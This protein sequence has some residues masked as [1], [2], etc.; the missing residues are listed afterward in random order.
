MYD[1]AKYHLSHRY[2]IR[3]DEGKQEPFNL[4][5]LRISLYALFGKDGASLIM[6]AIEEELDKLKSK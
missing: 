6:T 4:E 2:R 1:V 3:L 5:D